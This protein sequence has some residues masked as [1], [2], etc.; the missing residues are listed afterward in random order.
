MS[1]SFHLCFEQAHCG[2]TVHRDDKPEA[3]AGSWGL[4]TVVRADDGT[5]TKG[6]VAGSPLPP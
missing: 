6:R 4:R 2:R 1:V 3:F 5:I